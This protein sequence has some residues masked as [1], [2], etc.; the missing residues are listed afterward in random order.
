MYHFG[1][2]V[3]LLWR[4]LP[5]HDETNRN[6][7]NLALLRHAGRGPARFAKNANTCAMVRKRWAAVEPGLVSQH[8]RV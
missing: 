5:Q 3:K 7:N 1:L 6:F 2:S 8:F 4:H